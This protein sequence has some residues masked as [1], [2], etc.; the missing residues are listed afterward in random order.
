[1]ANKS[2]PTDVKNIWQS[3]SV[4]GTTMS[5]GEIRKKVGQLERKLRWRQ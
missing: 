4:E 3:Q 5:L 1:M 2:D